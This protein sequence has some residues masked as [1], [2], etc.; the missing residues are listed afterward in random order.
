M[1]KTR[2]ELLLEIDEVLGLPPGTLR[3]DEKLEELDNW[4]STSLIVLIALAGTNS[5]LPISPE[6]VLSCSTVAD[7]LKLAGAEQYSP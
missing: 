4:D 3:G 7:F 6:E 5:D 1:S 2:S